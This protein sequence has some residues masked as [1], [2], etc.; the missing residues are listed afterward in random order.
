MPCLFRRIVLSVI[1]SRLQVMSSQAF[2]FFCRFFHCRDLF[3]QH[4]VFPLEISLSVLIC[5]V[6]GGDHRSDGKQSVHRRELGAGRRRKGAA[7]SELHLHETSLSTFTLSSSPPAYP[8]AL[9][10]TTPA[11][12]ACSSRVRERTRGRRRTPSPPR[13]FIRFRAF[14]ILQEAS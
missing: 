14:C 11:L 10:S 9:E 13:A 2:P 1:A 3:P 5:R 12:A 7:F 4:F 6:A 8:H